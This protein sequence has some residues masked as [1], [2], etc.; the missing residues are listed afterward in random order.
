MARDPAFLF[1]YQD[2]LVGTSFMT[3]EEV[4]AY[5]KLLC[6]Q[7]DK[8]PLNEND[9]LKKIPASIW[10]KIQLKFAKK[11]GRFYNE[12]LAL[13]VKKR[14]DFC[15]SRREN[16]LNRNKHMSN[17]CKTYEKHMGNEDEDVNVN[18]DNDINI[19]LKEWNNRMPWKVREISGSRLIHLKERLKE[20]QFVCEFHTILTKILESDF[21]S[22]RKPSKDH[23]NFRADLDFVIKN[24]TNYIKILEGK[25]DNLRKT[26]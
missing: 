11:N 6:F 20:N 7:A 5:I 1:Y 26:E 3:L 8:G 2:F 4:G 15:I 16:R 21:L 19:V 25:Y 10:A 12:R 23:P 13:E 9:I 22:G 18:K 14:K 24:N 17:I